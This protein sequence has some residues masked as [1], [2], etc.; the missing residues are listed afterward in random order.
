M[1]N[2]TNGRGMSIV[3]KGE[4]LD[5]LVLFNKYLDNNIIKLL[6]RDTDFEIFLDKGIINKVLVKISNYEIFIL[7]LNK[8]NKKVFLLD[9]RSIIGVDRNT[10]INKTKIKNSINKLIKDI[11]YTKDFKLDK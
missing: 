2:L 9:N 1:D 8:D 5:L 6:D 11:G 3:S 7:G 10:K 4:D